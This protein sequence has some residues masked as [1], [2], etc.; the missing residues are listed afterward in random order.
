MAATPHD[1][2]EPIDHAGAH[3]SAKGTWAWRLK[4]TYAAAARGFGK[5]L[6]TAR[7]IPT[8]PPPRSRRFKHWL[9]SLTRVHDSLAIAELD[10]PWWTYAAI[11]HVDTWLASRGRPIRVFEWGSGASTFWLASR[12]DSVVSV[13]HH[14]EFAAII[15]PPLAER[16]NVTFRHVPGVASSRPTIGS[17]KPGSEGLDF[18]PYVHAIDDAGGPFDLIVVDGRAREAC[19]AAAGRHLAPGGL[20][21]FDNSH[22]KRYRRAIA[23]SGL[24]EQ[25]FRGLTPTLPYPDR[26]SVLTV[27]I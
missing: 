26:T 10:V 14:R 16:A 13:E 12:A 22:R 1:D 19:L 5:V 3:T 4:S 11:D 27:T 18:T 24:H 7:I 2:A 9:T 23:A 25:V 17:Q 20:I 15:G 21:V 6:T 8:T